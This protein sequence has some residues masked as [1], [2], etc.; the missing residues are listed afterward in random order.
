MF[1][2]GRKKAA[3]NISLNE[4]IDTDK[5]GNTLTLLDTMATDDNILEDI[6]LHAAENAG[7]P[8]VLRR[9]L[10]PREEEI[11]VLRY[12]LSGQRPLVQREV[13]KKLRISRSFISRLEKKGARKAARAVQRYRLL[14]EVAPDLLENTCRSARLALARPKPAKIPVR[15]AAFSHTYRAGRRLSKARRR[16]AAPAAAASEP[17]GSEQGE[18]R[19]VRRRKP[20]L[21]AFGLSGATGSCI[22]NFCFREQNPARHRRATTSGT[23]PRSAPKRPC[24]RR[25]EL[26]GHSPS[27]FSRASG[28]R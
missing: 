2:A 19:E 18:Q 7:W 20:G 10:S 24:T 14:F 27:R 15:S 3:Q 28:R 6:D 5:D 25:V 4:P 26:G 21:R 16:R 23:A 9:V 17:R 1:S 8:D 22:S 11:I 12:G 13:A